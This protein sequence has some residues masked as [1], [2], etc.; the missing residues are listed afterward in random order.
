V[1]KKLH[2]E[3]EGLAAKIEI[4][5]GRNDLRRG[6]VVG[7]RQRNEGGGDLAGEMTPG[8][9]LNQRFSRRKGGGG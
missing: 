1:G 9:K 6:I 5:R 8:N 2:N 4:G 3:G 7:K